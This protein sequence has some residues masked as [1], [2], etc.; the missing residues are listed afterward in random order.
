MDLRKPGSESRASGTTAESS[1]DRQNTKVPMFS[2][3]YSSR[4]GD[5][6]R[7][8]RMLPTPS[9]G[10]QDRYRLGGHHSR[11]SGNS[12]QNPGSAEDKSFRLSGGKV[13]RPSPQAG[14]VAPYPNSAP[15]HQLSKGSKVCP[16][17][18]VVP[19]CKEKT[20]K[21]KKHTQNMHLPWFF[22]DNFEGGDAPLMSLR[23]RSLI[24]LKDRLLG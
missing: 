7:E 21:L 4:S 20:R 12:S 2:A 9:P 23:G 11:D 18:C 5:T 15:K 1:Q 3:G 22:R 17:G 24:D 19:E 13:T 16:S 10:G 8:S 6:F 14:R